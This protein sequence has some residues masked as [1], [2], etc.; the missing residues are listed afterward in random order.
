MLLF[1]DWLG[2]GLLMGSR[3][4]ENEPRR[5]EDKNGYSML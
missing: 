4:L 5:E 1:F 2:M 3:V